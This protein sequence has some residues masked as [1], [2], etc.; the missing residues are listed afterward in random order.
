[1]RSRDGVLRYRSFVDDSKDADG[2][3]KAW[4]D[5]DGDSRN[6]QTVYDV[7]EHDF[8]TRNDEVTYDPSTGECEDK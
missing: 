1:M 8:A 2:N 3:R 6:R 7:N 5:A 4:S